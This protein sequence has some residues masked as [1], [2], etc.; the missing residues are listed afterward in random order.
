MIEKLDN[1]QNGNTEPMHMIID[2]VKEI[3]TSKDKISVAEVGVGWGATAVELVKTLGEKDTYYFFD[4]EDVVQELYTDLKKINENHINLIGI[5]NSRLHYD[6]YA[7]NLA[8]LYMKW[9]EEYGN[10]QCLDVVYLDGAHTFLFDSSAAC[11][12]KEMLQRGGGDCVG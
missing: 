7:W 1:P 9:K 12:L 8:K 6:S 3:K 11:I 10:V 4:F 5:G 2:L